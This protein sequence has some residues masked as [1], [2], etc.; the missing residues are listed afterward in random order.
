MRI[1]DD[2]DM[3][4]FLCVFH[5]LNLLVLPLPAA[6]GVSCTDLTYKC[7]NNKCISKVNPE[8]DGTP[9]CEDGSDEESC[10]TWRTK[11]Q[12]LYVLCLRLET[13]YYCHLHCYHTWKTTC[14]LPPASGITTNCN[15]P[16]LWLSDCFLCRLREEYV[17]D[18]AY[19]GRSGC[20]ARGVSLA[21]QPPHQE[22]WSRVRSHHHQSTLAG[23]RC[24]LCARWRQDKVTCFFMLHVLTGT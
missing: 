5:S 3:R 22:F 2:G 16:A 4:L 12:Q 21:G 9:D 19:C 20:R 7:K 13:S 23:H 6:S 11:P 17:P 24:P 18:V 10:G 14:D 8:C 1:I 15:T